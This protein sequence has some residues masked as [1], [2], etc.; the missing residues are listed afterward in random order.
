MTFITIACNCSKID[1]FESEIGTK[2]DIYKILRYASLAG[3]SHNTQPWKTEIFNNDSI[4]VSAD[5]SRLLKI[6]DPKGIELFI[7]LGAFIENLDIAAKALGYN[8]ML[9]FYEANTYSKLQAASIKISKTKRSHDMKNLKKLEL[10]T[11]LRIPFDTL[12]VKKQ[13]LEKLLAIDRENIIFLP[14]TSTMGQFMAEK[15]LQAYTQ[16]SYQKDAQDELASWIRFSNKDV[17]RKRDGL[18]PASMGIKGVVGFLVRNFFKPEDSKKDSFIKSGIKKTKV[19]TENCGGWLVIT[20]KKDNSKEWMNIG[21]IYERLNIECQSLNLG[22]HPMNQ[23]IEI[24]QIEQQVN[25]LVAPDRKIRFIA[26]IGY[27][28]KFPAPVS[29]RRFV[30]QFMIKNNFK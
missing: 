2:G 28:K 24:T 9:T 8:T 15:E 6:V 7:S 21:R 11:T 12:A 27:V 22:F 4:I 20:T 30:E 3:S 1:T 13:D 25:I 23:I 26:R 14:A 18:T 17:N 29:K 19:Q 10:R 16:Q 5:T